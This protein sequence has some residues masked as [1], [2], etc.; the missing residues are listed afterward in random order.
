[1]HELPPDA[2]RL[3]LEERRAKVSD[4]IDE[5]SG[6]ILDLPRD[7]AGELRDLHRQLQRSLRSIE[8]RLSKLVDN[9]SAGAATS[10]P[11]DD[12][13]TDFD[14]FADMLEAS[15]ASAHQ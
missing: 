9:P 4:W 2:E 11:A 15:D 5:I 14:P 1:M 13:T 8:N 6:E 12:E 7:E 10:A 3:R